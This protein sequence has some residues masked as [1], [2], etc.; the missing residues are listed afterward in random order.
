MYHSWFVLVPATAYACRCVRLHKPRVFP[1]PDD[2][3]PL[4]AFT[5]SSSVWLYHTHASFPSFPPSYPFIVK[6]WNNHL[7]I[8]S[9]A[10][11]SQFV[12]S[13]V[14]DLACLYCLV[15]E[16]GVWCL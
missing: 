11:G 14:L 15:I 7:L 9:L 16:K 12:L 8:F 3:W 4:Q 10:L 2:S 6:V 1:Q 13:S 5:S